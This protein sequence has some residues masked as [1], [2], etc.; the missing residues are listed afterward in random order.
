MYKQFST[1]IIIK[2]VIIIFVHVLSVTVAVI[3]IIIINKNE[4]CGAED[5]Q[6][7]RHFL[8]AVCVEGF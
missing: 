8:V 2:E 6:V 7:L 5:W 3:I 1:S 4:S